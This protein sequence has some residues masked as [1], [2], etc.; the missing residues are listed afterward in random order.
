M[1][2]LISLFLRPR[3]ALSPLSDLA[4]ILTVEAVAVGLSLWLAHGG[5]AQAL[6]RTLI[7]SAL[8]AG[9]IVF[10]LGTPTGLSFDATFL[11]IASVEAAGSVLAWGLGRQQTV[12]K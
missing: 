8:F 5:P 2:A 3:V 12:K 10:V 4:F 11:L 7:L 6:I 1:A 9:V